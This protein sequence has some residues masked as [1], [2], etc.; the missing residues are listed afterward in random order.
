M[1][2]PV[3]WLL[4]LLLLLLVLPTPIGRLLLDL[5]GG[6][7]LTLLLLP[8]LGGAVAV[9]GWQ[10][11]KRRVRTCPSC[12]VISLGQPVCPACGTL[13]DFGKGGETGPAGTEIDPRN[14]TINV[15]AVDVET[16]SGDSPRAS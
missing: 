9:I 7:T 1:V 2:R 5:V 13:I 11:L 8:L 4:L 6:L 3:P 16:N 14:V 15:E 10:V 12:G